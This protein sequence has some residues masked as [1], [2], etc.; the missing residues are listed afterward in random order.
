MKKYGLSSLLGYCASSVDRPLWI[1]QYGLAVV[2]PPRIPP[3]HEYDVDFQQRYYPLDA[4]LLSH[5]ILSP[6][7]CP[8]TLMASCLSPLAPRIP[9]QQECNMSGSDISWEDSNHHWRRLCGTR[10]VQGY[11]ASGL[12]LSNNLEAQVRGLL[13]VDSNAVL[14]RSKEMMM[15]YDSTVLCCCCSSQ[16][17]HQYTVSSLVS[18]SGLQPRRCLQRPPGY[19]HTRLRAKML[20]HILHPSYFL[21]GLH[22]L[23]TQS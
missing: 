23:S 7:R 1:I 10:P 6:A 4:P 2:I 16:P 5:T 14:M 11:V 19:L 15:E 12:Q 22:D 18:V 3:T 8:T 20:H 9:I 21:P 17:L 13:R